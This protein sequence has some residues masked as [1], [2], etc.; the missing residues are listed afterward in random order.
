M[1]IRQEAGIR[2]RSTLLPDLPS[3]GMA[4]PLP[5][6]RG[7]SGSRIRHEPLPLLSFMVE[8]VFHSAGH[9][10]HA[11]GMSSSVPDKDRL[12][13]LLMISPVSSPHTAGMAPQQDRGSPRLAE[14]GLCALYWCHVRKI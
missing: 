6:C 7:P 12:E 13:R 10:A 11:P 4:K 5:G 9:P 1:Q 2:N 8:K 3:A 14:G